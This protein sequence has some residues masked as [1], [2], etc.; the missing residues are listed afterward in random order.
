MIIAASTI[1]KRLIQVIAPAVAPVKVYSVMPPRNESLF[2]MLSDSNE[3]AL[4][5][6]RAF[7]S[8]GTIIIQVVQKFTGRDGQLD[9]VNTLAQQIIN[10]VTPNRVATF[11]IVDGIHIFSQRFE[12]ANEILFEGDGGRTAVKQLRFRYMIQST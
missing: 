7:I 3:Q 11:G 8:D 2:V 5:E 4:D 9:T 12:V 6:K 10:A 1:R